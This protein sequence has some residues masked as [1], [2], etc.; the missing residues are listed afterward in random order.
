[1]DLF[2][3][4]RALLHDTP[5]EHGWD[6]L[7]EIAHHL[8]REDPAGLRTQILP[9]IDDHLTRWP[10]DMRE[11]PR[12]WVEPMVSGAWRPHFHMVRSLV[13]WSLD[14]LGA[15]DRLHPAH[16][17][18]L[19]ILHVR[20]GSSDAARRVLGVAWERLREV[21]LDLVGDAT[22]E[23]LHILLQGPAQSTLTTLSVRGAHTRRL[24]PM[25]VTEMATSLAAYAPPALR[26][27]SLRG[28]PIDPEHID[29]LLDA[30]VLDGVEVLNLD[31]C[32]IGDEGMRRLFQADH[33]WA[34]RHLSVSGC[35]IGPVG[36]EALADSALSEQL[37]T[38]V[39]TRNH[40]GVDWM[41]RAG[42]P[43]AWR[44]LRTL[45]LD[46]AQ[47][48]QA[49]EV[50]AQMECWESLRALDVGGIG[51]WGA[52]A[53]AEAPTLPEVVRQQ[54]EEMRERIN[55]Q[56]SQQMA[57]LRLPLPDILS[58]GTDE[59]GEEEA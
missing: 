35:E 18:H 8:W 1:M 14:Q 5:S 28:F 30:R 48:P 44:G 26:R 51:F 13:G 34:L 56:L 49:C 38:L 12:A 16:L 39:M 36:A 19:A 46:G 29:V 9:Y 37:Q 3:D 17:A 45:M 53:L 59:D 52:E 24:R 10:D 41:R 33:L 23:P 43:G 7:T 22:I 15:P 21:A 31:L 4:I 2:G 58:D 54:W 32:A 27:L 6:A 50:I 57:G 42:R 55:Q 11:C 40:A 47:G 25:F 20:M